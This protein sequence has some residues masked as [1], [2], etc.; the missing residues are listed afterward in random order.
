[1]FPT[2]ATTR[3]KFF[4]SVTGKWRLEP[5]FSWGDALCVN[6]ATTNGTARKRTPHV[7]RLW[8]ES[9]FDTDQNLTDSEKTLMFESLP[10]SRNA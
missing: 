1:M 5:G 8:R 4:G 3:V 2:F 9:C 7:V 6:S 10:M